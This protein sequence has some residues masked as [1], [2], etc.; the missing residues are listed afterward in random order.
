M[1]N[2]RFTINR[3]SSISQVH[4]KSGQA[5]QCRDC[6]ERDQEKWSRWERKYSKILQ[7]FEKS[8]REEVSQHMTYE[9]TR[10]N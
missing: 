8:K 10:T 7:N 5:C 9:S 4:L 1:L 2:P 6:E 3:N